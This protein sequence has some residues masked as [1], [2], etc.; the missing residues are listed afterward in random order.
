MIT[1]SGKRSTFARIAVVVL[2]ISVL[3][4][5]TE[6]P[7][8]AASRILPS[9]PAS[10]A[11]ELKKLKKQHPRWGFVAVDT[12]LDWNDVVRKMYKKPA[13][14]TVWHNF[15][16]AYR[17][18]AKGCYNYL[19]KTYV[20]KDGRRFY[21]ASPQAVRYYLDP[22]NWLEED[23]VFMFEDQQY[24]P[25]YQTLEVV[26]SVFKGRN[27]ALYKN[28]SVFVQAARKYNIS[29][30]YLAS[31]ALEE[32]GG[33][34]NC[35]TTGGKKV[36]NI[37]NIGAYGS[38]S[39]GSAAKGLHYARY[40]FTYQRPWTSISKSIMGGAQYLSENYSTQ[41]QN[42]HYLEHFNVM[43]GL[44][45]VGT[46]VYMTAIYAPGSNAKITFKNYSK[47]RI[48]DNKIVFR[49]PVYRN[50][51]EKPCRPPSNSS[52]ANNDFYLK[53][54]Y[55]MDQNSR[56]SLIRKTKANYTR[57]FSRK[58]NRRQNEVTIKAVPS[59]KKAKV[60]GAG[61]KS[62]K[63]GWNS[64]RITVKATSGATRVYTVKIK[65]T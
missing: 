4:S 1:K 28:A 27:A 44:G 46:H 16:N 58:V 32:Q 8:Y 40:G 14:N 15:G 52:K 54:L 22:R 45:K 41:N 13:V 43:N 50:M 3:F 29:A 62:L 17:S 64:F 10:Y 61:K 48:Q 18:T 11:S 20:P 26:Q 24:H 33:K 5:Y 59:F 2:V 19:S 23:T 12:G 56:L 47:Y 6:V 37:F 51:P 31:K 39:G 9:F 38:A 35:G 57:T 25:D 42:S 21:A 65:R 55:V 36:Y 49:I 60:T 53:S 63:V 30:I 34:I 7:L